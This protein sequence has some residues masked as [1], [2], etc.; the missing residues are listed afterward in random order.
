VNALTIDVRCRSRWVV[1]QCRRQAVGIVEENRSDSRIVKLGPTVE[2]QA[3]AVRKIVGAQVH[4]G[5]M[6]DDRLAFDQGPYVES[7]VQDLADLVD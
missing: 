5:Q 4:L 3:Q 6:R 1:A 7:L 2:Q